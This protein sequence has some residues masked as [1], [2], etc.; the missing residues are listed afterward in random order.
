MIYDPKIDKDHF[1][2]YAKDKAGN[3]SKVILNKEKPRDIEKS[4]KLVMVGYEEG[5]VF[6]CKHINLKCP[7]KYTDREKEVNSSM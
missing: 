4:E 5:G 2:F 7:S 1:T 6:H 3:I